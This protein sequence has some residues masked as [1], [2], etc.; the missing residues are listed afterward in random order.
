MPACAQDKKETLLAFLSRGVAMVHLD[1]R[2]PGVVVPQQ[3][4]HDPH[5]RLNLSYGYRIPDFDVG[6]DRVQATLSFGGRPFRC[7]LPWSAIF[8]VTSSGTGE[9]QVWPEDLPTEAAPLEPAPVEPQRPKL[10]AVTDVPSPASKKRAT[11]RAGAQSPEPESEKPRDPP[12]GGPRRNH[13]R[14]VR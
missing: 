2:R 11:A 7:L 10:A 14:L 12:E 1:A 8:A 6:E 13:L 4:T 5:L 3:F 9:G